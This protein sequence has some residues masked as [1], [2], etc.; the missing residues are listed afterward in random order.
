MIKNILKKIFLNKFKSIFFMLQNSKSDF[1]EI[2]D[3]SFLIKKK[4]PLGLK[5]S[6]LYSRSDLTITPNLLKN[7]Q[8]DYFIIDFI[9]K[10]KKKLN[11]DFID[12]GA[13][14]GLITRQLILKKIKI[15]N[16]HCIEPE[17]NNFLLLKKNLEDFKKEKIF[18]YNIALVPNNKNLKKIFIN[19]NNFGDFSLIKQNKN[20]K[21]I[22]IHIKNVN[23]FLKKIIHQKNIKNII[24]KSDIQGMDEMVALSIDKQIQDKIKIIILEITNIKYLNKELEKFLNFASK[25][26]IMYDENNTK[27][28]LMTIKERIKTNKNFNLL[29]AKL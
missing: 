12:V 23:T 6:V 14:I 1:L 17:K 24:Y 13:N 11:Y 28:N 5:N 9:K 16:F 10:Y 8:W 4:T 27:L 25:F 21:S 29:L 18:F 22:N 7:G 20:S 19:K 2:K 3:I 15:S 26:P